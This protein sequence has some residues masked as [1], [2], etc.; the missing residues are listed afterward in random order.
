MC[1]LLPGAVGATVAFW[2]L[3]YCVIQPLLSEPLQS[4]S[5]TFS[6]KATELQIFIPAFVRDISRLVYSLFFD[7]VLSVTH[8][9][10]K[11]PK[12]KKIY[13]TSTLYT[14]RTWIWKVIGSAIRHRLNASSFITQTSI[15]FTFYTKTASSAVVLIIYCGI[16]YK[17]YAGPFRAKPV[18]LHAER[19]WCHA[20]GKATTYLETKQQR[21]YTLK[22]YITKSC[23]Y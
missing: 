6:N 20:K 2:L 12:G 18:G 9:K 17:P 7:P 1:R 4:V 8:L 5:W 14:P 11:R 16:L 10:E 23:P 15:E 21:V 19:R 13:G 22:F 3:F